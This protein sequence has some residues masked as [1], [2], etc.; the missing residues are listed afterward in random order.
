MR[1]FLKKG[2]TSVETPSPDQGGDGRSYRSLSIRS[3]RLNLAA[4]FKSALFPAVCHACGTVF[5]VVPP[6]RRPG[7]STSG[8]QDRFERVLYEQLCPSC[9]SQAAVIK[10]PICSCCGL[11]FES[12]SGEDHLCPDCVSRPPGFAQARAAGIYRDGLKGAVYQFKYKGRET[13]AKSLG[14][15]LWETLRHYWAPDQFDRV[16]AVPLHPTRLRKRG[17]NQAHALVREWPRLALRDGLD[18]PKGWI[19]ADLLTRRRPTEP[20]TG[21][22]RDQRKANLH[23]AF[24]VDNR[25]AVQ[26]R[27][28]LVVD[29]VMTTGTTADSCARTLLR[30]G[31]GC[32]HIL[33]LARALP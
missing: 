24:R 7:A 23:G 21:L 15:L 28:I 19:A 4:V 27:N 9:R 31:A 10:K 25:Q 12:P 1:T 3:A 11:P 5:A 16:V 18:L 17:F 6:N 20:Q 29:D 33:T 26:N 32:V 14:R 8:E 30:A 22:K 13:L 2:A